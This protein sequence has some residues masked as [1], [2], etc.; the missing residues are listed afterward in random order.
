MAFT[1]S[2]LW[3]YK[4]SY[5]HMFELQALLIYCYQS[6]VDTNQ[7][8][9]KRAWDNIWVNWRSHVEIHLSWE[10][11]LDIRGGGALYDDLYGEAYP[12]RGTFLGLLVWKGR[13]ICHLGL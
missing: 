6:L 2:H 3:K 11:I 8:S 10:N 4:Y 12:E 1:I 7:K 5:F 13:E 9:F